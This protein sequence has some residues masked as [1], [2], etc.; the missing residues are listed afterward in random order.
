MK[1]YRV[2]VTVRNN[3]LLSAIEDAGFVGWGQ[4]AAFARH[5]GVSVSTLQQLVAMKIPPINESGEF[6][7]IAKDVMEG[8]G[9]APLDL[10]TDAQLTAR[11]NKNTGEF[12]AD[13]KALHAMIE[14]RDESLTLPDPADVVNEKQVSIVVQ[15][16]LQTLTP[17]ESETLLR[18]MNDE[19][20]EEIG[21][22]FDVQRERVRQIEVKAL[23]KMRHPSRRERLRDVLTDSQ[24]TKAFGEGRNEP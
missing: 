23:R 12:Y 15:S 10:W 14:Q 7:Q 21:K 18:R 11:L 5:I 2:K 16:V 24:Y 9:A 19:T 22:S 20:M 1:E 17:R 4:I 3:L 13:E 8:L 6:C